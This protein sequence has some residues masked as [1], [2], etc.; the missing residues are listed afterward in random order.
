MV[1]THT[2][3]DTLTP[4]RE[5]AMVVHSFLPCVRCHFFVCGSRAVEVA[6]RSLDRFAVGSPCT[7]HIIEGINRVTVFTVSFNMC[8][9]DLRYEFRFIETK[10]KV[11][12]NSYD[13]RPEMFEKLTGN[14]IRG[15]D[16]QPCNAN[17]RR[18]KYIVDVTVS[19]R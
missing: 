12:W 1:E 4:I 9:R 19:K 13:P 5:T 11:G 18:K 8:F 2:G 10:A 16:R 14:V 3:V 15:D 17:D 6:P 7:L